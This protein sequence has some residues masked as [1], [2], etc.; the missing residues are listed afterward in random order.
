[1]LY[2]YP[3]CDTSRNTETLTT[4]RGRPQFVHGIKFNIEVF[5]LLIIYR[6]MMV[7]ADHILAS[8]ELE[9][10]WVYTI[11]VLYSPLEGII[12]TQ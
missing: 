3:I 1:M 4:D 5:P 6:Y 2:R 10:R 7:H 9:Y 8:F 11:K 12:V